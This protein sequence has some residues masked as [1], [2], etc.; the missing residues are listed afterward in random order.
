M[1]YICTQKNNIVKTAMKNKILNRLNVMIADKNRS[2]KWFP[3]PIR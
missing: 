3:N 2:N 1:Y